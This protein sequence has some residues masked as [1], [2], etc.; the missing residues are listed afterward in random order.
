MGEIN[1]GVELG[2]GLRLRSPVMVASGTFA[3]G[4]DAPAVD[5][6]ALGAAVTKAA[7]QRAGVAADQEDTRPRPVLSHTLC[8]AGPRSRRPVATLGNH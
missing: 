3:Y 7:L 2:R 1:L 6:T 5:R 4:F 8:T